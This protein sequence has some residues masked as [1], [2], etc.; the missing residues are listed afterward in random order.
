MM[1]LFIPSQ[2]YQALKIVQDAIQQ[3]NS[4]KK[5]FL[6]F[7]IYNPNPTM[8]G[9][10]GLLTWGSSMF[11]SV[12]TSW[13]VL[14]HASKAAVHTVPNALL[15]ELKRL[16]VH[17]IKERPGPAGPIWSWR[18]RG[19]GRE[20]GVEACWAQVHQG[21]SC[22]FGD[23]P[24]LSVVLAWLPF[25]IRTMQFFYFSN[26]DRVFLCNSDRFFVDL[27]RIG[28][29]EGIVGVAKEGF[30]SWINNLLSFKTKV[31]PYVGIYRG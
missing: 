30:S 5:A 28:C 16:G 3:L 13:A 20:A 15:V 24:G 14:N 18:T 12:R 23:M 1:N 9:L 25:W 21:R 8:A 19:S 22:M 27:G 2:P 29:S 6:S 7:G 31:L 11:G 17:A 10:T 26:S 4:W